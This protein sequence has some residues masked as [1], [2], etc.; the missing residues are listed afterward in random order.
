MIIKKGLFVFVHLSFVCSGCGC[1]G[2]T[3]SVNVHMRPV[4]NLSRFRSMRVLFDGM[5][6]CPGCAPASQLDPN[7]HRLTNA[8]IHKTG[9]RNQIHNTD[10][11]LYVT[12]VPCCA[13]VLCLFPCLHIAWC[14]FVALSDLMKV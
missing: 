14:V 2:E 11:E 1:V 5:G 7:W 9:I 10:R 12:V 8:A 6:T 4:L 13:Y 3:T